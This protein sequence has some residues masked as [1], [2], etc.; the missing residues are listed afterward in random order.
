[1]SGRRRRASRHGRRPSRT[2]RAGGSL[3]SASSGRL[4]V[5]S[6]SSSSSSAHAQLSSSLGARGWALRA[7][8]ESGRARGLG[9]R[10]PAR[11]CRCPA[12]CSPRPRTPPSAGSISTRSV[13]PVDRCVAG[14]YWRTDS[15]VSPTNSRRTGCAL[16]A[17]KTSTTPPRTQ[18]SPWA[19]TGSS[20][21]KPASTSRSARACGS[22][23]E[24]GFEARATPASRRAGA[25]TRGSSPAADA[26]M[27]RAEPV[28]AAWSARARADRTPRCGDSPR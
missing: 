5:S 3:T 13:S 12:A 8:S 6:G 15:T 27:T 23:S 20:R 9:R 17:G 22:H 4:S 18:N 26:T 19:S 16:A 25:L 10:N 1:M 24:P 28:A 21:V 2:S 7:L 11:R 14:S